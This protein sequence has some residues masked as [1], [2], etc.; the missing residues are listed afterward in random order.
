MKSVVCTLFEGHYS[1]GLA[2][3]I[4]SLYKNG[5]KGEI[6]AGYKGV[7]PPWASACH[8]NDVI[9]DFNCLTLKISN[10]ICVHFLKVETDYHF[11]NYKPRFMLNLWNG[12]AKNADNIF[13]FDPDI[14]SKCAWSFYEQWAQFGVALVHEII[15]NDMPSNHPK[16]ELWQTVTKAMNI[17]TLNSLTSNINSGFVGINKLQIEFLELWLSL[18]EYSIKYFDLNASKFSQSDHSFSLFTVADQDLFNLAS[19]C[20]KAKLSEVG[21]EGMDFISGGWIMS[22]ATGS[23]KPWK[24]KFLWKALG[25]SPPSIADKEYWKHANG[26]IRPYTNFKNYYKGISIKIASFI[27]RFYRKY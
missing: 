22:H 10:D 3:L 11:A 8:K 23:P 18:I 13:Y 4:N 24:K 26:I 21:P 20:T 27:G 7:L 17:E 25:A 1:Y 19:M 9:E 12:P 2:A 5:F 14:V 6:Y 15:W 16:R